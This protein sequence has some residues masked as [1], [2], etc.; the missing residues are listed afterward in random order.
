ML[1][2][3][4][5]PSICDFKSLDYFLTLDLE[6]CVIYNFHINHLDTIIKKIKAAEKKVLIHGDMI[7]GLKSDKAGCEYLCQ[8]LGVDGVLSIKSSVLLTAKNN[9][10]LAI[11][12]IFLIDSSSLEKSL[13]LVERVNPD[14]LEVLPG[15]AIPA[16]KLI[17][18]TID[19]PMI[20]GGLITKAE[21]IEEAY[22]AGLIGI[23]TGKKE[24]WKL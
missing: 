3:K 9:G 14:I 18:K 7:Q 21:E 12:R 20:G 19:I 1:N 16:I 13:E 2:Q 23:S 10:C 11:Q 8:R 15:I 24:L 4:V 5:I 22:N 6:Y 17:K